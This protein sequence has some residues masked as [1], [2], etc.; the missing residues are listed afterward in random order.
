MAKGK[1]VKDE[2]DDDFGLDSGLDDDMFSFDMEE[3]RDDRTPA[4]KFKDGAVSGFKTGLGDTDYLKRLSREVLPRGFGDTIDAGSVALERAKDVYEQTAKELK[5]AISAFKKITT[6]YAPTDSKLMPKFIK[7]TLDE[8]RNEINDEK[9]FGKNTGDQRES[10]LTAQMSE[11]FAAQ[12]EQRAAERKTEE[13]RAALK[14]GVD[15]KRFQAQ[16]D[17]G[18]RSAMALDR[19]QKYQSTIDL[20]FKKKSLEIQYRQLFAQQDMLAAMKSMLQLQAESLPNIQ[21][22]TAL[23]EVVKQTGPEFLKE[24]NRKKF[25]EVVGSNLFGGGRE[26]LDRAL[27]GVAKKVT[28]GIKTGA[29]QFVEAL[30]GIDQM[31]DMMQQ[32]GGSPAEFAGE[33]AGEAAVQG[34]G[35]RAGRWLKKRVFDKH[36]AI[37]EASSRAAN[38][39]A[40]IPEKINEFRIKNQGNYGDGI[41]STLKGWLADLLPGVDSKIAV[42][43]SGLNQLYD[44]SVFTN[45]AERSITEVIPGYL[46]RILREQ[47]RMRLKSEDVEL[48]DFDFS[49]GKFMDRSSVTKKITESIYGQ[50][51]VDSFHDHLDKLVEDVGGQNLSPQAKEALKEQFAKLAGNIREANKDSLGDKRRYYNKG[52]GAEEAANHMA[53]FMK[54]LPPSI[55][56]SLVQG[57]KA[58]NQKIGSP[59]DLIRKLA[60]AGHEDV[61]TGMN[62][63]DSSGE[64]ADRNKI[65]DE[66][67][68]RKRA[69]GGGG[70]GGGGD[71][72]PNV[73]PSPLDLLLR[74]LDPSSPEYQEAAQGASGFFKRLKDKTLDTL[75]ESVRD[76]AMGYT[77]EDGESLSETIGEKVSE[78]SEAMLDKAAD[79][80][81]GAI[82]MLD[83]PKKAKEFYKRLAERAKKLK[84]GVVDFAKNGLKDNEETGETA[85]DRLRNAASD[86][87]DQARQTGSN[88]VDRVKNSREFKTLS[89][90]KDAVKK[91]L[92]DSQINQ[93]K[94]KFT[95]VDGK[96]DI[97]QF[98]QVLRGYKG[99]AEKQLKD[100]A[101]KMMDAT[102]AP[103]EVPVPE[104]GEDGQPKFAKGGLFDHDVL[105]SPKEFLLNVGGKVK[106]AL[107]GEAGQEAILPTDDGGVQLLDQAGN[108]A[109]ILP[110]ARDRDGRLSVVGTVLGDGSVG[111][112]MGPPD[113]RKQG[114]GTAPS[115]G[116]TSSI[117]DGP[118]TKDVLTQMLQHLASIDAQLINGIQV[119]SNPS[120]VRQA[121]N[122]TQAGFKWGI[123]KPMS[124]FGKVFSASAKMS[125]RNFQRL[126]AAAGWAGGKIGGMF[127]GVKD[128]HVEG[129][130][131]NVPRIK[132]KLLKQGVYVNEKGN[133]IYHQDDIYGTIKDREGNT[134]LSKDELDKMYTRGIGGKIVKFI[135]KR[136][137]SLYKLGKGYLGTVV[138]AGLKMQANMVRAGF[139]FANKIGTGLYNLFDRPIDIYVNGEQDPALVAS[140]MKQGGYRDKKTLEVIQRPTQIRGPVIDDDNNVVLTLDQIR[141]GITDV[142]G[143]PIRNPALKALFGVGKLIKGTFNLG[144]K[145]MAASWQASKKLAGALWSGAKKIGR[146]VGR[147]VKGALG[148]DSYKEGVYMASME[149]VNLLEDIRNILDKRLPKQGGVSGDGDGDGIKDGTLADLRRKNAS[150]REKAA[151]LGSRAKGFAKRKAAGAADALGLGGLGDLLGG[152]K[153]LFSGGS[154]L[155][156]AAGLLGI[157]STAATAASAAT[158][159]AGA[160]APAAAAGGG[161]LMTG[162]GML[163]SGLVAALSSPVVLGVGAAALLGYGA[164]KAYKYMKNKPGPF[165]EIRLS[166]YGF[167][168]NDHSLFGKVR[169]FESMMDQAARISNQDAS[170]DMSKVDIKSAMEVWGLN[171]EN[172]DHVNQFTGWFNN[173]FKPVYLNTIAVYSRFNGGKL[174]SDSSLIK[175]SDWGAAYK[176]V[177]FE[178]GPYGYLMLPDGNVAVKR[179]VVD[180][181]YKTVKDKYEIND[182]RSSSGIV[183][184][185]SV[186]KKDTVVKATA[187]GAAVAA[188]KS[189]LFIASKGATEPDKGSLFVASGSVTEA[190]ANGL[191]RV[192]SSKQ[193]ELSDLQNQS[194]EMMSSLNDNLK[195]SR[196]KI[197]AI[198][199]VRYKTYGLGVMDPGKIVIFLELETEVDKHFNW[200][201]GQGQF[202]GKI[203][204]FFDFAKAKFGVQDVGS[205]AG[206]NLLKWITDRFMPTYIQFKAAV[207]SFNGLKAA[208]VDATQL[209]PAEQLIIA[210]ML[211]SLNVWSV[212]ASPFEGYVMNTDSSSVVE[213]INFLEDFD[214]SKKVIE[215]KQAKATK[216]QSEIKTIQAANDSSPS[217]GSSASAAGFNSGGGGVGSS[218][219]SAAPTSS[220]SSVMSSLPAKPEM[221]GDYKGMGSED[222][223]KIVSDAAAIVGVD[224][225]VALSTVAIESS[226]NPNAK[227]PTSSAS[228][229]YQFI[230]RTWG[231]M[232]RKYGPQY[233]MDPATMDV[234]DPK[235]NALMGAH[236]I[237]DNMA[238]MAKNTGDPNVTATDTY[239]A[240]FLGPAGA[241]QLINAVNRNPGAS[242]PDMMPKEAAAN[243]DIFFNGTNPRSVSEVYKVLDA[244]VVAKARKFGID[245][246]TDSS[247]KLVK[248]DRSSLQSDSSAS[249]MAGVPAPRSRLDSGGASNSATYQPPVPVREM[250]PRTS[251]GGFGSSDSY[252]RSAGN[253]TIPSDLMGKTENIL[254]Q[255]LQVQ[256]QILEALKAMGGISGN[257]NAAPSGPAPEQ[258][259]QANTQSTPSGSKQYGMPQLPVSMR[260]A[261]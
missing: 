214:K 82:D 48:I 47:M 157:G 76:A 67:L 208:Q 256:M 73:P 49:S 32:T 21:K 225:G 101:K 99:K 44:P 77:D 124:L 220:G 238:Y 3:P 213:N 163:G 61:L 30:G 141:K 71:N 203:E 155:G 252:S 177:R 202:T 196:G 60:Y 84:D 137:K 144:K 199:A 129:D 191:T 131:P 42:N 241:T 219:Y 102:N 28:S 66:F 95:T 91:E 92:S 68:K 138:P 13:G 51:T 206:Q 251:G 229:L 118:D 130:D 106:K 255:Q 234:F 184:T 2:W 217:A 158:T 39:T 52:P 175:K 110:L 176:A 22:N 244:K 239:A 261:A 248:F 174:S 168:T 11:I 211:K 146:T 180:A 230:K 140:V 36:Q 143:R 128:I 139:R 215:E 16:I 119:G 187:M 236:Y 212:E 198:D 149:S 100:V 161:M 117:D 193:A 63:L 185:E 55:L 104:I 178:S 8:W 249:P 26:Y 65:L 222:I 227:A 14:E 183:E 6:K 209:K 159:V 120:L 10:M 122:L 226:F 192:L 237:K 111:E 154:M 188:T 123:A 86:A 250:S 53:A 12:T 127:T 17:L 221:V 90:L 125:G 257:Q 19:M 94:A 43:K 62:A 29:G 1:R 126:G 243:R 259:V 194:L 15:T 136:A 72:P 228:G 254:S 201:K 115:L 204:E 195:G 186:L 182:Q 245:G 135:S 45:K 207:V 81:N 56:E 37:G 189:D 41:G 74:R 57:I 200:A 240:H 148:I 150:A 34:L 87:V 96:F 112:Y 88:L 121:M 50:S 5:P 38:F 134:I 79:A 98:E 70:G 181:V 89:K 156:K 258:M 46:A 147:A 223:K 152:L 113:P 64:F 190:Q 246:K 166:Q 20:S 25:A 216:V 7:D 116:A 109:G 78:V 97:D 253:S 233:G 242:A 108:R 54:D 142:Y 133:P 24:Y 18:N 179:D 33:M 231:E 210:R 170:I 164:Y 107:A 160:A 162:L 31:A 260:R 75:P 232:T 27:K 235:A 169:E 197:S 93:L 153:G 59:D 103:T 114:R 9:M 247:V 205:E 40:N 35:T 151:K 58:T 80:I 172:K 4:G 83:D 171:V 218:G 224:Q 165:D 167:V 145:V 85:T 105:N 69:G 23:P 173:R 132:A